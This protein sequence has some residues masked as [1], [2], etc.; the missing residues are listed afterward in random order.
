MGNGG[1]NRIKEEEI[2]QKEKQY[3]KKYNVKSNQGKDLKYF[4]TKKLDVKQIQ[5]L[6]SQ[7]LDASAAALVTRHAYRFQSI[8]GT[9]IGWSSLSSIKLFT[10]LLKLHD[11]FS[12]KNKFNVKSFYPLRLIFSYDEIDYPLC[13]Y[14]GTL[15]LHP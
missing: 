10:S 2:T 15:L 4:L 13:V 9:R 3:Y 11:E 8:D 7:R 12:S 6:K 14:S 5:I 1:S